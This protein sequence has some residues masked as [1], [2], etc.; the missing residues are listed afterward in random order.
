MQIWTRRP[1][2]R[3]GTYQFSGTFIV[4]QEV[5]NRLSPQEILTIYLQVQALVKELGGLD[6]LQVFE[7]ESGDKLYFM[8]QCD[9]DMMADESYMEEYNY[10]TLLFSHEY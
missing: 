10:C 9:P 5:A 4:T 1:Q 6:Y 3:D 2:E 8:D 7:N